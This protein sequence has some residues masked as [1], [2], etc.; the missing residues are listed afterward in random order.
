MLDDTGIYVEAPIDETDAAKLQTGFPV[1]LSLD[2]YPDKTFPASLTRV[3]PFVRDVEGQNRTVDVEC[4]FNDRD[5]AR[6]LLPGTSADIEIILTSR[7]NVLR[8]PAYALMEG[9]RVLI[10]EQNKLVA[11]DVKTGLRNW[12]YVEITEGLKEGDLITTSLERAEVKE[13]VE[14][15]VTEVINK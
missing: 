6:K 8:I 4:E 5:F 12:D 14:V 15:K 3:A 9:N 7:E 2:P 10:I 13:G 11:R 1:R